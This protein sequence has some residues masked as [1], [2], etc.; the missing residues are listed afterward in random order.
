MDKEGK[1]S[2]IGDGTKTHRDWAKRCG[3]SLNFDLGAKSFA[4]QYELPIKEA[5]MLVNKYHNEAYPEIRDGYHK[6]ILDM[7]E[8]ERCTY[9]SFGRRM[10][11][12]EEGDD[13]RKVAYSSIAQSNTV[14]IINQW[15]LIPFFYEERF[16]HVDVTRQVHDSINFQIPIFLGVNGIY[17]LLLEMKRSLE[18]KLWWEDRCIVIPS[19]W[20]VGLNLY[21][22]RKSEILSGIPFGYQTDLDLN[23]EEVTKELLNNLINESIQTD[24]INYS[25][26]FEEDLENFR[27]EN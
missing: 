20:S 16:K 9:N 12:F 15:G 1:K 27:M 22:P 18:R 24:G 25:E 19:D 6:A 13:L 17:D 7:L 4:A 11:F 2:H 21:T 14:D 3:H 10:Y 5:N 26:M 8:H 23:N